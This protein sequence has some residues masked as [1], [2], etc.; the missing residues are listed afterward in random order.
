MNHPKGTLY[1]VAYVLVIIGA[2][3]WG[4]V[5]LNGTNLV[6]AASSAVLSDDYANRMVVRSVYALVALSALYLVYRDWPLVR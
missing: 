2:L 4:A 3:N 6:T 1:L 5:A